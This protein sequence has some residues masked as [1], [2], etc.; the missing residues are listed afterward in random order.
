MARFKTGA[1]RTVKFVGPIGILTIALGL[2]ALASL[3]RV[4]FNTLHETG[5]VDFHPYW[6]AGHAVR[7]GIDPYTFYLD[8][9][10]LPRLPHGPDPVPRL[11]VT[12][13]NSPSLLLLLTPFSYL[14][15][16][17]AKLLWMFVNIAL[18]CILPWAILAVA[19][20]RPPTRVK[21]LFIAGSYSLL[22]SR[23]LVGN[24]QT[25][26]VVFLLLLAS[27]WLATKG[28][29][30]ATSVALGVATAKI[31]LA[32]P[33]YLW[34]ILSRRY[35]AALVAV[36]IQLAFFVVLSAILRS[37]PLRMVHS[38]SAIVLEHIGNDGIHLGGLVR[39]GDPGVA[40]HVLAFGLLVLVA[41]AT[42]RVL[43]AGLRGEFIAFGALSVWGLLAGYHGVY[44]GI[45]ALPLI[46][47]CLCVAHHPRTRP[48]LRRFQLAGVAATATL[49][50]HSV[51]GVFLGERLGLEWWDLGVRVGVSV[52]LLT[53][54][55]VAL[56][57]AA[58]ASKDGPPQA[59][60]C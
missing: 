16:P 22:A 32:L 43:R 21:L 7:S 35:R 8:S 6:Y 59:A 10:R 2:V 57:L 27:F 44:D 26:A 20:V 38:Y 12:P 54:L 42:G 18:V 28:R 60:P 5:A 3:V 47:S 34:L 41:I 19:R 55:L 46:L 23:V 15:W 24:G 45:A 13:A 30:L 52:S 9:F 49:V 50:I 58:P 36:S 17:G 31:S 56:V 29:V 37:N 33:V 4:I 1:S 40:P 53:L 51:P 39:W 11:S 25:S 48:S 14:P